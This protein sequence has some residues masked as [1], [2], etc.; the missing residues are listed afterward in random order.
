M[1]EVSAILQARYEGREDDLRALLAARPELDVFEAAAV[2]ESERVHELL[3]SDPA[4]VHAWSDDGFTP[5]HLACFFDHPELVESLL[6]AGADVAAVARNPMRVQPLHSAAA[7]AGARVV[8]A[9]LER[10]AEVN[11]RQQGGFVPLHAAAQNGDSDVARLLLDRGADASL[12]TDVGKTARD[13][14]HEAGHAELALLLSGE[15]S[16]ERP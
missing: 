5:L 8:A 10:G 2:G 12:A 6:A 3:A 1:P 13:L 4:R 15:T 9:L 14:A 16:P 11:A 7:G